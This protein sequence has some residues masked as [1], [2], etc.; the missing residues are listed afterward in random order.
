MSSDAHFVSFRLISHYVTQVF[1]SFV[2][3]FVADHI[4]IEDKTLQLHYDNYHQR[5]RERVDPCQCC[6]LLII[7]CIFNALQ[8]AFFV[9]KLGE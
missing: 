7:I 8:G 1:F 6:R 4:Q 9:V 3:T 5:E 2:F